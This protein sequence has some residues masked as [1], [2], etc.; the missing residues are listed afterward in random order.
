MLSMPDLC[1]VWADAASAYRCC[2]RNTRALAKR[3]SG[4]G[5][6]SHKVRARPGGRFLRKRS[7]HPKVKSSTSQS[8]PPRVREY[9]FDRNVAYR[10]RPGRVQHGPVQQSR[11]T[12]AVRFILEKEYE[13]GY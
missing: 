12:R 11:H 5:C 10:E 6:V 1:T 4:R 7:A 3:A 9:F 13:H 2:A 8:L